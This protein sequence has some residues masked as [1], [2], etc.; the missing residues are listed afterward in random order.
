VRESG[1][2]AFHRGASRAR[3]RGE[4]R[5]CS[6]RPGAGIGKAVA[7]LLAQNGAAVVVNDLSADEA[8]ATAAEIER[9]GGRALA[10]NGS[11]TADGFPEE[12]VQRTVG[13][14]KQEP[15]PS[16]TTTFSSLYVTV[17]SERAFSSPPPVP[18]PLSP[19]LTGHVSSFPPY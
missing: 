1:L 9:V 15:P 8:R 5:T 12:L 10:V 16:P 4:L 3:L 18:P 11:V 13:H 19:V 17:V 2:S 14:F 6:L 7:T